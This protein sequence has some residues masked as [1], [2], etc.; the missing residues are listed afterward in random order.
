MSMEELDSCKVSS[1]MPLLWFV[2]MFSTF[3]MT[4]V[5]VMSRFI[6]S[7]NDDVVVV[8]SIDRSIFSELLGYIN[9]Q[10]WSFGII[11]VT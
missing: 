8:S 6:D 5:F 1:S 4:M 7:N 3:S 2:A 10:R 9:Y 11:G